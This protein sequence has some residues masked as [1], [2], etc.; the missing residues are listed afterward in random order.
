MWLFNQNEEQLWFCLMIMQMLSRNFIFFVGE[1]RIFKMLP[2]Q[3]PM[4]YPSHRDQK[5]PGGSF[6]WAAVYL[7]ILEGNSLGQYISIF[8]VLRLSAKLFVLLGLISGCNES[9]GIS[10]LS[11]TTML[12][13]MSI[14]E[15]ASCLEA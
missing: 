15:C 11:Y 2:T 6:R 8:F 13:Y 10:V 9:S 12:P 7:Y 4:L 5:R 1:K 3:S 14:F